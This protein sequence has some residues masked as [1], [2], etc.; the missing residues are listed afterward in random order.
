MAGLLGE[1]FTFETPELKIPFSFPCVKLQTVS[2]L[3][4][5]NYMPGARIDDQ[6]RALEIAIKIIAGKAD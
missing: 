5:E 6:S 3:P 4:R 2:G 1:I